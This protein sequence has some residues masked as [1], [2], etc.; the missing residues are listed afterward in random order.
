MPKPVLLKQILKVLVDKGFFFVC[1]KGSHAK[2]RKIGNPT[3]TV[4]GRYMA[5]K[6]LTA[7][8]GLFYVKP[9]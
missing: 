9:I 3:I 2:Y 6:C 8:F 4:I 5:K 7:L 1:Q